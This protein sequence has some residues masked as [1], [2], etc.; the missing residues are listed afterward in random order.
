MNIQCKQVHLLDCDLDCN[1]DCDSDHDPDNLAQC[2]RSISLNFDNL[3]LTCVP[4]GA[5][6]ACVGGV[7]TSHSARAAP[8]AVTQGTNTHRGTE[9]EGQT[10]HTCKY[11]AAGTDSFSQVIWVSSLPP[12]TLEIYL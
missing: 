10:A 1:P 5:G 9:P 8:P 4:G 3:L 12:A 2:K 6:E 11:Q 7:S